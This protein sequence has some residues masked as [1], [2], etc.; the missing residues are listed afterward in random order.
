MDNM[1]TIINILLI[2]TLLYTCVLV[3]ARN[4]RR[5]KAY[6]QKIKNDPATR[7]WLHDHLSGEELKDLKAVKERYFFSM[8]QA[9]QLVDDYYRNSK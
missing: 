1:V 3:W 5:K 4:L 6:F 2:L 7:K 8:L 9:K